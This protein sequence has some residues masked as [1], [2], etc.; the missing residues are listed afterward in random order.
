MSKFQ[1][2]NEFTLRKTSLLSRFLMQDGRTPTSSRTGEGK[3]ARHNCWPCQPLV[4]WQ[5]KVNMGTGTRSPWCPPWHDRVTLLYLSCCSLALCQIISG[6]KEA[7]VKLTL[8]EK[9]FAINMLQ[10]N[11]ATDTCLFSQTVTQIPVVIF[12]SQWEP[13]ELHRFDVVIY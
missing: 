11:Y 3:A 13:F 4:C 1:Y 6:A 8:V 9:F 10:R 5:I 12:A 2:F 7:K